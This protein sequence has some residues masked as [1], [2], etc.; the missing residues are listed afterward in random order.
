MGDFW[1]IGDFFSIG[2]V[3]E[4]NTQFKKKE[5]KIVKIKNV[6]NIFQNLRFL[7][8][9]RNTCMLLLL[10]MLYIFKKKKNNKSK[11]SWCFCNTNNKATCSTDGSPAVSDIHLGKQCHPKP[12]HN[13]QTET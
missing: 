13:T 10:K 8:D 12:F 11:E 1:D 4:I 7:M 9:S 2:N 5:K 3:K 6:S